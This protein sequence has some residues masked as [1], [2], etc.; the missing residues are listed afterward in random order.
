MSRL[1]R[2]KTPEGDIK[3]AIC[4][5]LEAIG[6]FFYMQ[7]SVGIWDASK[8]RYLKMNSRF[9]R[10]G[11]SDIIGIYNRRFLAIEVK[12]ATGRLSPEQKTF[13]AEVTAHGGIA[14]MAR[15]VD[16]VILNLK[17]KG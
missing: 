14:F 7:E 6:V 13:L 10:K 9:Q 5:Y 12:S 2:R 17:A 8:G 4:E 1:A 16:D 11:K 15:S 3:L